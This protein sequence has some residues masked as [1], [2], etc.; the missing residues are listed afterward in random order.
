MADS[1]RIVDID[2]EMQQ[3]YLD[4]AMSVIVARALPDA[5]DGLKPVQRRIL[6]G[7]HEL[8]IRADTPFKKSA[9]IVGEVLGKYH[10][11]GDQAVYDAMARL[12]QDFSMRYPL[13]DGQGNFGSIDG[14]PP[15]AMRY[16]EA[17]LTNIAVDIL[18]QLD[19]NTIDF[20]PNFDETL[21]EPG[22]LPAAIPNMLVNGASGIAVGMATSI[23]PHN[24]N[25]V[26]DAILYLLNHWEKQEEVTVA[27]LTQFV[28]GPDFPTGGI[29]LQ[30]SQ[31][32]D[33]QSAYATGKGK[34]ILRGKIHLEEMGRGKTSI[35]ITELPYQ[36]NKT[37]LIERIA[38]LARDGNIEGITDLRD[39]S[40]RQGM[41]I[42]I[43]VSKTGD[44]EKI[45]RDLYK[46]TPLQS[47]FRI[48]L[49]AL[50]NGEPHMLSLK[51]ALRV[52]IEHRIDVVTRRSQFDLDKARQRAHILEGLRV[53][54]KNLD[55]VIAIIRGAADVDEARQ[56]LMAKFKLS[57]IQ[58]NAILEMQLRR[59]AALERKK[60]D[61][62]Y[63]ELKETILDLEYLLSHPKRMREVIGEE[64]KEIKESYGDRRRTQ[65]VSLKEGDSVKNLLTTTDITPS[66]NVWVGITK[67]GLIGRSMSDI[68]PTITGKNQFIALYETNTHHTLYVVGADGRAA[69]IAVHS[70]PAVEEFADG[71][72]VH[73]VTVL[74]SEIEP[75]AVFSAP[76]KLNENEEKYIVTVSKDGLVKK[77]SVLDLPGPSTQ[78]F[79]LSKTNNGDRIGWVYLTDGK[80]DLMMLSSRGMVIRFSEEEVRAMGLLAAGVN[81]MKLP[82]SDEVIFSAR[83]SQKSELM[84]VSKHGKGWRLPNDQLS[85][86]GRYGQG[87]I[88]C[89]PVPGDGLLTAVYDHLNAEALFQFKSAS[90]RLLAINAIPAGKRASAGKALAPTKP[91]DIIERV[92]LIDDGIAF[93]ENRISIPAKRSKRGGG[94][95]DPQPTHVALPIKQSRSK[96]TVKEQVNPEQPT[97][98]NFM[99]DAEN[100][101]KRTVSTGKAAQ[102]E[103]K[104]VKRGRKP[105]A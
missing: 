103:I 18:S 83:V 71:L 86:Q 30:E 67:D 104:P 74:P 34:V 101:T 96:K 28:K 25:E 78:P 98:L 37:S 53:A 76:A 39:E 93:W 29:I 62:E 16:T 87:N 31:Q 43:E 91:G 42:V 51:Q 50:V 88:A 64:L 40:D 52:Y 33:L 61:L 7:M 45:L 59:L 32:D 12:A 75:V 17:R 22:V 38:E 6:Y 70:L 9:R 77:S 92:T 82:G 48:S 68:L 21:Q 20:S 94:I 11:H 63:K 15:A 47:T 58:A 35:I 10:P 4:Y 14:D 69:S 84:I 49:L 100:P 26:I 60:I 56:K 44:T 66:Q 57:E 41:R 27:E 36:I 24:L 3:S 105:K 81:G 5:R 46:R 8:G 19:R 89:K 1:I 95:T 65:I 54:L 23:P 80:S 102:E 2:Q 97:L 73:K 55:Q 13:I 90:N 72:P 85:V 99:P 79:Y